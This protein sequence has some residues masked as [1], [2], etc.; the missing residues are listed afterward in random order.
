MGTLVTPFPGGCEGPYNTF[1]F[2]RNRFFFSNCRQAS[3]RSVWTSLLK[4]VALYGNRVQ[5]TRP[6]G[7]PRIFR[8][9]PSSRMTG[10]SPRLEL[11]VRLLFPT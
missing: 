6:L 5:R 11:V 9:P 4:A 7:P 8:F 1:S 10:F 2:P 3:F